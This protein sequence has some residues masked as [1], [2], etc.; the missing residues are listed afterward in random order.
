LGEIVHVSKRPRRY[1]LHLPVKYRTIGERQWHEGT[2]LSLSTSG[3]VIEGHVMPAR[4]GNIAVVISLPSAGGCLSGRGHI[5]R[6]SVPHPR[7]GHC[8]FAIA[9]PHYQLEHRPAAEHR[10]DALLQEC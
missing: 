6:T 5:V 3:A 9:V 2:T 1:A 8:T 4:D 10:L 7:A